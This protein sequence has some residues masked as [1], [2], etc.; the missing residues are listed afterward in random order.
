M[1]RYRKEKK[2]FSGLVVPGESKNFKIIGALVLTWTDERL[3]FG[4]ND[5]SV[6]YNKQC[7]SYMWHP[8]ISFMDVERL[9]PRDTR[10]DIFFLPS[11]QLGYLKMYKCIVG[12][13]MF[14]EDYPFDIQYCEFRIKFVD[15]NKTAIPFPWIK[16]PM[17]ETVDKNCDEEHLQFISKHPFPIQRDDDFGSSWNCCDKPDKEADV[18]AFTPN[19]GVKS[20]SFSVMLRDHISIGFTFYRRLMGSFVNVFVPSTEE[21]VSWIVTV[22][23]MSFWIKVEAAPARVTLSVT[24]LLTFCTQAREYENSRDA[25]KEISTVVWLS[26]L[27]LS[28]ST[29]SS[30]ESMFGKCFLGCLDFWDGIK[31]DTVSRIVFPVVFGVFSIVYWVHYLRIYKEDKT[32]DPSTYK[33]AAYG[34]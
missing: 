17:F 24:S 28:D 4:I 29:E 12:C 14:Y 23:W 6:Y 9:F 16:D 34:R 11:N 19:H 22:S 20:E 15:S 13:R 18:T 27:S 33:Y 2:F 26:N 21:Y 8:T 1:T 3:V 10:N 25:A 31:I 7:L 30:S 5:S 32:T